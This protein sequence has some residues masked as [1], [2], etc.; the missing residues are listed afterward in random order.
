MLLSWEGKVGKF[1][2]ASPSPFCKLTFNS[3]LKCNGLYYTNV[4]KYLAN[5]GTIFPLTKTKNSDSEGI[6]LPL[7]HPLD[8]SSI[9][10][11]PEIIKK[12]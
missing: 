8:P 9:P 6:T 2:L 3:K 12:W 11:L 4:V 7:R 1:P 5:N 10:H